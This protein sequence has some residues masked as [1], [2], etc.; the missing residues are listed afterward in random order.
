MD[1]K[2]CLFEISNLERSQQFEKDES[3]ECLPSLEHHRISESQHGE[4][5]FVGEEDGT[6][7]EQVQQRRQ[8][9]HAQRLPQGRAQITQTQRTWNN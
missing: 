7:K 1:Q 5:I 2:M 4:N 8:L 9:V 3:D 6:Q